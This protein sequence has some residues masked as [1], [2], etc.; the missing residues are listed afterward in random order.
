MICSANTAARQNRRSNFQ[1]L[2]PAA[3]TAPADWRQ[4]R[5]P[6]DRALAEPGQAVRNLP[7]THGEFPTISKTV[8]FTRITERI[9]ENYVRYD[10][11]IAISGRLYRGHAIYPA[12][13][14]RFNLNVGSVLCR[15]S[16]EK[17]C[18]RSGFREQTLTEAMMENTYGKYT[19]HMSAMSN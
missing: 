17:G 8:C 6:A 9:T 7:E 10:A 4:A 12:Q 19:C 15:G 18:R 13:I 3:A 11:L 2:L 1:P 5:R 14:R 16:T